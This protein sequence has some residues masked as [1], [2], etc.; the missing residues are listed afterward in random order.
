DPFRTHIQGVRHARLL[1]ERRRIDRPSHPTLRPSPAFDGVGAHRQGQGSRKLLA[2]RRPGLRAERGRP[3]HV[4][5]PARRREVPRAARLIDRFLL[6]G[7]YNTPRF[8]L[9]EIKTVDSLAWDGELDLRDVEDVAR[10]EK[11]L[12]TM[13][14]GARYAVV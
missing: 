9:G 7:T 14:V 13:K 3:D 4:G 1:P 6:L 2:G 5:G 12:A 8:A 11:V 10:L